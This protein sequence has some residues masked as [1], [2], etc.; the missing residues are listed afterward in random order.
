MP[1]YEICYLDEGGDL[2]RRYSLAE[3]AGREAEILSERGEHGGVDGSGV[4]SGFVAQIGFEAEEC[5]EKRSGVDRNERVSV[6]V[7]R[8]DQIVTVDVVVPQLNDERSK[9]IM[10]EFANSN[11]NHLGVPLPKGR[12]RFYRR[13]ADGQMEFT[14]ENQIDR[15]DQWPHPKKIIVRARSASMMRSQ[16]RSFRLT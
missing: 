9:E 12:V 2:V 5:F 8:G 15:C 10:R 3:A 4:I 13:D 6:I 7:Q 14:G 1:A 11:A 16:P